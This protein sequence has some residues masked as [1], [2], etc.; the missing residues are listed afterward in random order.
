MISF[1]AD[2]SF[3]FFNC[4]VV[5]LTMFETWSVIFLNFV[6]ESSSSSSI[7]FVVLIFGAGG[8]PGGS[9]FGL[10]GGDESKKV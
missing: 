2:V 8:L 9:A 6:H 5:A 4:S 7:F 10:E 3:N 1:A